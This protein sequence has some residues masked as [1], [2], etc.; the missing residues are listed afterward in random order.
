MPRSDHPVAWHALSIADVLNRL[1]SD[2]VGL[3]QAQAAS[4][5]AKYDPERLPGTPPDTGWTGLSAAGPVTS[6]GS[7]HTMPPP[8][9]E[10]DPPVSAANGSMPTWISST[11]LMP[12]AI[13]AWPSS[14]F[15]MEPFSRSP[16]RRV[17]R[18]RSQGGTP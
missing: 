6:I 7:D 1:E 18:K 9:G 12:I 8:T 17:L 10:L 3:S 14:R 13:S 5:L 4:R 11:R 15:H 16:H 2:D